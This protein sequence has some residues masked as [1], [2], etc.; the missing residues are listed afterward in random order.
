MFYVRTA[1]RLER[2]ATWQRKLDGGI[3]YVRRV[4]IDDALGL[5]AELEA[6]MARHVADLRVRVD[7]DARRP[8][9]A[10]PAS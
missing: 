1:E 4:V 9:T 10:R 8:G 6:D 7:G 5:G 2:T 3:D